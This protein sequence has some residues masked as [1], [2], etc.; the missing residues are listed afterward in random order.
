MKRYVL[1][2]G[3]CAGKTTVINILA[4]RGYAVLDETARVVIEKEVAKGSDVLPW[5]NAKKFQ[6]TVAWKQLW[7][8][9][10]APRNSVLFLDRGIIDGYGYSIMEKVPVPKVISWFG[11]NRYD[12]V[13][14]LD[15]LPFYELDESR[16]EDQNFAYAVHEEIRKAYVHFGYEVISVPILPPEE[17]TD[18][19]LRNL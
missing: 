18:F 12:T 10:F 14:L 3:P 9:V 19:V 1:T 2:G 17:R 5:K 6:E 8:E 4:E 15:P 11:K 7:K 13:F 16:M